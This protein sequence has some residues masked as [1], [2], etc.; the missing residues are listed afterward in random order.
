MVD[1]SK[2]LAMSEF[3][4]GSHS[5]WELPAAPATTVLFIANGGRWSFIW[6]SGR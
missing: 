5:I 4:G 1:V 6:Y 3:I 2:P